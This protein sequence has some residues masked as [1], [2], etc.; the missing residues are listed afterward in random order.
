MLFNGLKFKKRTNDIPEAI[1]K[2][3]P[4]TLFTDL[5][6]TVSKGKGKDKEITE[7]RL[8]LQQGKNLFINEDFLRVFT[9]NLLLN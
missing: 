7:R 1:L 5:Y 9:N 6:V 3:K 4:E 2:L 8:N